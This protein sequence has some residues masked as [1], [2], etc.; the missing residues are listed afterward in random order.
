VA[1]GK[2]TKAEI[3]D[4]IYDKTG[5]NRNEIRNVIDL[6]INEVKEAL[7]QRRVIE[8]RKFGTFEIKVRKGRKEARNPKTGELFTVHS[9]GIVS[10][11][12]GQELKQEVWNLAGEYPD[13]ASTASLAAAE[14][15]LDYVSS[16]SAPERQERDHSDK[17][18]NARR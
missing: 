9:H 3:V 7:A 18:K 15:V 2:Y 5:I 12:P 17:A 10:F 6:F 13:G 8:L 4:S 11:R 14:P 1:A 16:G